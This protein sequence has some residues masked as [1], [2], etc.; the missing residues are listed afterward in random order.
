MIM[1]A[2][3]ACAGALRKEGNPLSWAFGVRTSSL[4]LAGVILAG[5]SPALALAEPEVFAGDG[6]HRE[7]SQIPGVVLVDLFAHW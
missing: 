7:V 5:L 6:A 3:A 4:L 1:R 2:G